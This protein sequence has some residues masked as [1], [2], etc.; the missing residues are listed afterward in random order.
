MTVL[1][2]IEDILQKVAFLQDFCFYQGRTHIE[3]IDTSKIKYP[4][5]LMFLQDFRFYQWSTH[6]EKINTSKTNGNYFSELTTELLLKPIV[7]F[8][9]IDK[10]N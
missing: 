4:S 1:L 6:D 9:K 2:K 3:K 5:K 8:S 7:I 10:L